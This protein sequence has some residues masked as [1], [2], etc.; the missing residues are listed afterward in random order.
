MVII[1]NFYSGT[2]QIMLFVTNKLQIVYFNQFNMLNICQMNPQKSC[3]IQV[4]LLKWKDT[5]FIFLSLP[6]LFPL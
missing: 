2:I 5:S 4:V 3:I 1:I 6:L